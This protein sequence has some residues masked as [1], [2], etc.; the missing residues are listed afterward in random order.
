MGCRRPVARYRGFQVVGE[1]PQVPHC[2]VQAGAVMLDEVDELAPERADGVAVAE[3]E[4]REG[5]RLPGSEAVEVGRLDIY[6]D[7]GPGAHCV[8]GVVISLNCFV[9]YSKIDGHK[10]EQA[11]NAAGGEIHKI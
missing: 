11:P 8:D 4:V 7:V 10:G 1:L 3:V 6:R 5:R 9:D 2:G